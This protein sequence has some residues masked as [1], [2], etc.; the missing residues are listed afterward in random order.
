M[1][2]YCELIFILESNDSPLHSIKVGQHQGLLRW[3]HLEHI[4]LNRSICPHPLKHDDNVINPKFCIVLMLI[5]ILSNPIM[6]ELTITFLF[7]HSLY[8]L[9][10]EPPS[11][12]WISSSKLL[13]TLQEWSIWASLPLSLVKFGTLPTAHLQILEWEDWMYEWMEGGLCFLN[14]LITFYIQYL[15][16]WDSCIAQPT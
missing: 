3:A 6:Q 14:F 4:H 8:W 1:I 13:L 12:I 11:Y 15:W 10:L 16:F 5:S 9:A 2:L 7:F